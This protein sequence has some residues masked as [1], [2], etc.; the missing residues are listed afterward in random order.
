MTAPVDALRRMLKLIES[1]E[2]KPDLIY[3]AVQETTPY[4]VDYHSEYAAKGREASSEE[5]S[6]LLEMHLKEMFD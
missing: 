1:G 2:I 3:I 5:L 4:G 6:D